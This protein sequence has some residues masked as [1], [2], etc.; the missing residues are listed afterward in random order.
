MT[1]TTKQARLLF[2]S[3][4]LSG[5]TKD[6]LVQRC[7]A[8]WSALDVWAAKGHAKAVQQAGSGRLALCAWIAAKA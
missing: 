2:Q 5:A 7:Q 4:P 6:D 8:N 1:S 3:M